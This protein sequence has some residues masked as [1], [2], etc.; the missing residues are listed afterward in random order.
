M[1]SDKICH[2]EMIEAVINRVAGNSAM[3]KG[4]AVTLIT[5][6]FVLANKDAN[7]VYFF[8]A[9][10]PIIV[11]WLLDAFNLQTERLYRELYDH[12]RTSDLPESDF[13]MKTSK[14]SWHSC[15]KTGYNDCLLSITTVCFYLPL[16]LVVLF[17]AL[18]TA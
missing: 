4:W 13:S 8:I 15:K 3:F 7:K 18:L 5:G 10:I 2:L 16:A 9:Y 1:K 6:I 17:V 11:F 14:R 12:V